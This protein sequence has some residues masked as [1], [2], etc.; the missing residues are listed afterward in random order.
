MYFLGDHVHLGPGI[1]S[2]RLTNPAINLEDLPPIDAI[3]LSH[4][5]EGIQRLFLVQL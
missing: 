4:F 5:H 3:V 1:S 2:K